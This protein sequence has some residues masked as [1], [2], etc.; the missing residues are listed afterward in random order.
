MNPVGDT[1]KSALQRFAECEHKHWKCEGCGC[2]ADAG[3]IASEW[4]AKVNELEAEVERLTRERD[5]DDECK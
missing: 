1:L 5:K 3:T 2:V 4:R